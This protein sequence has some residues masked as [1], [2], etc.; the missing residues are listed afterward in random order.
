MAPSI[1]IDEDGFATLPGDQMLFIQ[2]KIFL[3]HIRHLLG[4]CFLSSAQAEIH[5][6]MHQ[7]D[8]EKSALEPQYLAQFIA[9]QGCGPAFPNKPDDLYPSRG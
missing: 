2:G 8:I 3:F 9:C 5:R 6:W 1:S 7:L 4:S